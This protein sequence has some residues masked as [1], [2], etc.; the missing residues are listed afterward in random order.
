MADHGIQSARYVFPIPDGAT[1]QPADA[2]VAAILE[3][4]R[5]EYR[6]AD[7]DIRDGG[8]RAFLAEGGTIAAYAA[9]APTGTDVDAEAERRV[10][11]GLRYGGRTFQFGEK[12]RENIMGAASLAGQA[13]A[14]D[15][16]QPGDLMWH[17][18]G[19]PFVFIDADNNMIPMDAQTVRGFGAAGAQWQSMHIFAA[20]AIKDQPAGIPPDF[21]A[22]PFWPVAEAADPLAALGVTLPAV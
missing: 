11:T 17:G 12:S 9:P 22:D 16:A 10:A 15:G 8:M 4:G 20:R 3:G 14:I 18:G 7:D 1:E 21:A 2:Q 13:L 5:T 19:D 6:R